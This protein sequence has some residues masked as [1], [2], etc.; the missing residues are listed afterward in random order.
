MHRWRRVPAR[1]T[2]GSPLRGLL[3]GKSDELQ[4]ECPEAPARFGIIGLSL[5][6]RLLEPVEV[7]AAPPLDFG[8]EGKIKD[9]LGAFLNRA[10]RR[11]AGLA[12]HCCRHIARRMQAVDGNAGAFK[13][14]REI[15]VEHDLGKFALA[16]GSRAAVTVR[17]HDIVKVDRLLPG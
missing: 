14:P 5:G 6:A 4:A 17:Q 16:V 15:N 10:L 2:S 7:E 3:P 1:R 9:R 8:R 12:D 13:R 11:D